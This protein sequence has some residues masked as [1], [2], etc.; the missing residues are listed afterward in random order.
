MCVVAGWI[1]GSRG[2][3]G[4]MFGGGGGRRGLR[5]IGLFAIGT[6]MLESVRCKI[7]GEEEGET[8]PFGS[9]EFQP[10]YSVSVVCLF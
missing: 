1:G 10:V 6:C 8:N 9:F 7:E 3:R 2:F 4:W 5:G